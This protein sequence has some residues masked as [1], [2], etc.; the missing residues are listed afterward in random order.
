MPLPFSVP[1][2][3]RFLTVDELA[4]RMRRFTSAHPGLVRAVQI[5][6]STNGEPIQMVRIG[7]G[8]RQ[9]LFIG[10]PHPNEPIGMLTIDRLSHALVD[11]EVSIGDF[12]W[13]FIL[14][15]DPDG[16]R[17]NEGWFGGPFTLT[18]YARDFYRPP[19]DDQ[20]ILTFPFRTGAYTFLRPI[21]ETRALMTAITALR[22]VFVSSL[23]NAA[24]GGGYFYLS[25]YPKGIGESLRQ[26]LH[27]RSIPL[28]L[29]EPEIAWGTEHAP[30]IFECTTMAAHA[31]FLCDIG[32]PHPERNL[33]AGET[34]YG[35][36]RAI[37]DPL[38]LICEVP[39]FADPR[40]G[41]EGSTS[42]PRIDSV[43]EGIERSE[44]IV[45][46][47][48]DALARMEGR[49][50]GESPLRRAAEAI[51]PQADAGLKAHRRWAR[52]ASDLQGAATVA[53]DFSNRWETPFYHAL[54]LG[55]LRRAL[56]QDASRRPS[57]WT[58]DV[59]R[60]VEDRVNAWMARFEEAIDYRVVRIRDL[61]EVQLASS[62]MCVDR[63]RRDGAIE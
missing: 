40:I 54:S 58:Q 29:G 21:P 57:P 8:P 6:M 13:N 3:E 49:W 16:A 9:L 56:A 52:D 4:D 33:T 51:L 35:F 22:P 37:C 38:F 27:D 5:G 62:L 45:S 55:V 15:A 25:P 31:R 41:D 61:V 19:F 30:A 63:L 24:L 42:T 48:V 14:C 17:R 36:S 43:L 20:A 32:D 44:E 59:L 2:Y 60:D 39:Y 34:T 26:L 46:F 11:D 50:S 23:H 53:Q 47:G 7:D 10:C 18:D 28:A 1:A 12:T